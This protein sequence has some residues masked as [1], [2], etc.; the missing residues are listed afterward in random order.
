MNVSGVTISGADLPTA[1][2][3]NGG[4]LTLTDSTVSRNRAGGIANSGTLTLINSMVS[5]N[6][7]LGGISTAA[8][9]R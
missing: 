1:A 7:N 6:A 4:T 5:G 2:I 9:R 8:E 3:S